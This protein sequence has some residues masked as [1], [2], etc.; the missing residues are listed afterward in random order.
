[1]RRISFCGAGPEASLRIRTVF[2]FSARV[3]F[4]R[5]GF[6]VSVQRE[7]RFFPSFSESAGNQACFRVFPGRKIRR[8]PARAA[9]VSGQRRGLPAVRFRQNVDAVF[10]SFSESAG[11]QACFRVLPGRKSR[12]FPARAASVSG[13]R[14]GPTGCPL[15]AKHRCGFSLFRE[16]SGKRQG[17]DP[18]RITA[19]RRCRDKTG[20][21]R[22][23]RRIG[24]FFVSCLPAYVYQ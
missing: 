14:R 17:P 20:G 23:A 1:M 10:P 21:S 5:Y 22:G 11:N 7:S 19:K 24:N 2:S 4:Q 12:R 15:P 6:C 16:V 13:Q 3:S 18:C 9:S 8:F